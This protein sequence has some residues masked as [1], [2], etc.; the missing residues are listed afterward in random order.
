MIVSPDAFNLQLFNNGNLPLENRVKSNIFYL[1]N[2]IQVGY[3]LQQTSDIYADL[4]ANRYS[5][6]IFL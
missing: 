3:R 6:K 1:C 5:L 4:V 2:T